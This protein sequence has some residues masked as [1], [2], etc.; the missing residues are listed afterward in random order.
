MDSNIVIFC[1]LITIPVNT[2]LITILV[3]TLLH[4]KNLQYNHFLS[5]Q[6]PFFKTLILAE[7]IIIGLAIFFVTFILKHLL[8]NVINISFLE[9]LI[10]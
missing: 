5:Y 3:N 8:K 9:I 1:M 7:K 4:C 2:I 6:F 10:I